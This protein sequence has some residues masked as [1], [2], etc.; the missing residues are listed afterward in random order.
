[1]RAGTAL[2]YNSAPGFSESEK[3]YHGC[4]GFIHP[5]RY[6]KGSRQAPSE[7]KKVAGHRKTPG[8]EL[9][10]FRIAVYDLGEAAGLAFS[11]FAPF[12]PLAAFTSTSLAVMV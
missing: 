3:S 2:L 7:R 6:V 12:S 11:F 9:T 4:M 1:M 5:I 10:R 8:D